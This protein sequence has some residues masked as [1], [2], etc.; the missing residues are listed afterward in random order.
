MKGPV[1]GKARGVVLSAP[2]DM[3]P[4]DGTDL[5]A[6]IRGALY[7]IDRFNMQAFLAW[8]ATVSEA[9]QKVAESRPPNRL[10][11]VITD[12]ERAGRGQPLVYAVV[13]GYA[14]PSRGAPAM[15]MVHV[16]GVQTGAGSYR[17]PLG[18]PEDSLVDVTDEARAGKLVV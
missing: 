5:R 13:L 16:L 12:N 8:K 15:V 1:N 2:R 9:V 11:R 7:N 4:L 17:E 10:W 18:V 14:E 6:L 3:V